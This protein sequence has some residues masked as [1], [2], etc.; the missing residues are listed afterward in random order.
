MAGH[1]PNRL[2]AGFGILALSAC[3]TAQAQEIAPKKVD[4]V[5]QPDVLGE[6]SN[7]AK[8]VNT[9][10]PGRVFVVEGDKPF[11]GQMLTATEIR[12]KPK[13]RLV[14]VDSTPNTAG[15]FFI[16]A[17][18]IVVEDPTN[19]GVITWERSVPPAPADRGQA[20]SGG[21]GSGDGAAG[22]TGATGAVGAT[23]TTGR[24]APAL[25]LFVNKVGNGGLVVDFQG[26]TGG[27]GGLGQQGGNGGAG[28]R[29]G[30]AR[31]EY[32]DLPF[33]GKAWL[34]SCK[35]GPGQGGN[36][37]AGGGGGAG[38]VGGKGGNGGNV[39]LASTPPNI[40]TLF[41]AVR[42]N[43]G[44]GDGG[45]GGPAGKGGAG[46]AG[47]PEGQL[48]NFCNSAGRNGSAGGAGGVG[49]GGGK[50]D[51]GRPGQPFVAQLDENAFKV[52]FGF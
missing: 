47:G 3:L 17:D 10:S 49:A 6:V 33:G 8:A 14:F 9:V 36:G 30:P 24:D 28:A 44:G 25:T 11:P 2:A 22:G 39:T 20:Q 29:G 13:S 19:P 50:G 26:G 51:Q 5:D 15:H 52:L 32:Q 48:A 12:F 43:I 45:A 40:P 34:P 23:G 38:G 21:N 1:L 37:G 31:Q 41:Q 27:P 35:S 42:V 46:G 16:V 18:R 7:K 4:F